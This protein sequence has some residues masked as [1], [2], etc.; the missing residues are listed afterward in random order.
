[1]KK[2]ITKAKKI[3]SIQKFTKDG[4]RIPVTCVSFEKET[5]LKA[6]DIVKVTGFSKGKGFAGVVKRWGFA[7]GPRTHGQSDRLR[8]PGSIG[9]TTTPGRVHKGKKMPGHMGNDNITV[10]GLSIMDVNEKEKKILIKGLL[11]GYRGSNLLIR[12]DKEDKKFVPL[13][14]EGQR[15]V[16]ETEEEKEERLRKEKESQEK[17][18]ESEKEEKPEEKKEEVQEEKKEEEKKE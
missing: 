5:S 2:D 12:K 6:G 16:Q 17:L 15:D 1:M 10:I 13:M 4:K 3:E 11:P 8:A 14:K 9:Q 7:G 18:K